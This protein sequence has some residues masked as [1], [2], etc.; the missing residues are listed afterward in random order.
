MTIDETLFRFLF[1]DARILP[2]LAKDTDDISG[3]NLNKVNLLHRKGL[4]APALIS[5]GECTRKA[6]SR[7]VL[8]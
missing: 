3:K 4:A 2:H 8:G 5:P 1:P 7:W 6:W